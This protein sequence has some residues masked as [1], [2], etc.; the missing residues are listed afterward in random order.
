MAIKEET[1]NGVSSYRVR[2]KH[3]GVQ[4]ERR[5]ITSLREAAQIEKGLRR[6]IIEQVNERKLSGEL[7]GILLNGWATDA[8][9]SSPFTAPQS[10]IAI[11]DS[12]RVI[13]LYSEHLL[14]RPSLL[15]ERSDLM[16]VVRGMHER[17]LSYS[18]IKAFISSVRKV[19]TWAEDNGRFPSMRTNGLLNHLF[20]KPRLIEQKR[21]ILTPG[22]VK[23]LLFKAKEASHPWYPVWAVALLTGCRSGELFALRWNDV[24]FEEGFI[25]I[26][27]GWNG[28]LG[29]EK[30]TKSGK[31]R[32]IPINDDL[33]QILMDL[34]PVTASSSYVLP[35]FNDWLRGEQAK[36]LKLFCESIG[37]RPVKFHTLRAT[38]TT[39]LIAKGVPINVVQSIGGWS[40]LKTLEIYNR[41]AGISVRGAT[42]VLQIL[43]NEGQLLT[44]PKARVGGAH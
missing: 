10:Q 41:V 38:F 44:L 31:N 24:N 17:G 9:S 12:V 43:P 13:E 6:M 33:K 29:I 3:F 35:R 14:K 5:G 1:K 11:A 34:R 25:H 2:V 28:R 32:N 42:D 8:H 22:E 21:E 18:R 7:F 37:V 26:Q 4:R 16:A 40:D 27:R 15:I 39:H 30:S 36:V 23:T 19:L 20:K